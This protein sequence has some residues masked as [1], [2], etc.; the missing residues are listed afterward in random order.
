MANKAIKLTE[1]FEGNRRKAFLVRWEHLRSRAGEP[2]IKLELSLP[3]LNE[4]LKGMN[5]PISE[6]FAVMSNDDSKVSRLSLNVKLEGMTMEF[7][8]TGDPVASKIPAVSLTGATMM[9][10]IITAA[11]DTEKRTV[12]LGLVA[13]I[14]ASEKLRDWAWTHLH[15]EFYLEAVYSQTELF[16]EGDVDL[17]DDDD[18]D[19]EFDGPAEV[20]PALK[21][22]AKS[23]PD[24]DSF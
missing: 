15:N 21:P 20:A 9:K 6:A 17:E 13:Y 22:R 5:S 18:E 16:A 2:R 11:G 8:S 10:L 1:F 12:D 14:P 3:L 23:K 7:F 19:D 4:P 24:T